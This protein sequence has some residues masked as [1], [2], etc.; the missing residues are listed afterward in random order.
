VRELRGPAIAVAGVIVVF[1]T[2]LGMILVPLGWT[3]LSVYAI[4]K[5]IGSDSDEAQAA[6]LIVGTMLMVT[7]L[8]VLFAVGLRFIG[9]AMEPAKRRRDEV[10]DLDLR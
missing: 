4:V 6:A 9:K 3:G 7:T 1:T 10:T 8:V 5:W 2:A